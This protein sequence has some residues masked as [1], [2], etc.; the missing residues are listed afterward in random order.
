MANHE[1]GIMSVAPQHGERFDSYAPWN[2]DDVI[3]VDDDDIEPVLDELSKIKMYAHTID[4]PCSGLVH[5]GITLI[6][7]SEM[8]AFI[9]IAASSEALAPLKGLLIKAK[10]QRKYIIHFG[11]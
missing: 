3:S 10:E 5:C 2:Y 11:L 9:E 8:D 4:V 6:P 7:P 1:F